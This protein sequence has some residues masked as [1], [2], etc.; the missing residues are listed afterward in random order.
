MKVRDVS[1]LGWEV[2][3]GGRSWLE[4]EKKGF[5]KIVRVHVESMRVNRFTFSQLTGY[6]MNVAVAKRPRL[7]VAMNTVC[8]GIG[9]EA[10][11]MR[12]SGQCR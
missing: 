11:P 2:V 4:I 8:K 12:L 3:G 1:S 9:A 5:F 7:V 6:V 10:S